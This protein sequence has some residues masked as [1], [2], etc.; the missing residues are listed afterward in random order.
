M[1]KSIF[2]KMADFIRAMKTP[3]WLLQLL[4]VIQNDILFPVLG[5]IGKSGVDFLTAQIIAESKK[6]IPG[7]Q[8]LENVAS[9]FRET[10]SL[11][12]I[13]DRALNMAI[14]ILVMKLTEQ[15]LIK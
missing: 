3:D 11:K 14:N 8:K 13:G 9:S 5:E 1:G 15:G 7:T 10:F 2:Q 12:N 6:D 4:E